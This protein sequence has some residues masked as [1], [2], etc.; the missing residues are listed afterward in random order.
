MH[1]QKHEKQTNNKP[2]V[3]NHIVFLGFVLIVLIG[4]YLHFHNT[5]SVMLGGIVL[6][7]A[8]VAVAAGIFYLARSYVMKL[9]L[10]FHEPP[11]ART[12]SHKNAKTFETE[13]L[14]ISW[15]FLY[16]L[17]VKG[18]LF[19]NERKLRES[20]VDLAR[21]Q[22]GEKVLDVGCG[23]GSLAIAAGV[24]AGPS[25]EIYGID[26]APE[27]IERARKKATKAGVDIDFQAGLVEAI[28]FPD[29]TFDIVLNSFMVHHL[30]GDLKSK[31][32]AEMYRVL[33]PGGRLLIV[34]FEPPKSRITK[35]ILTLFLTRYMMM[36]DNSKI[37]P[38]LGKVGFVSLKTG[39][40]G[41]SLA[42]FV[43]GMK[44]C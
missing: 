43:S 24:K 32:F 12:H 14:T 20:I 18:I 11:A 39:N 36:I 22:P 26:A 10:K 8:H 13:G 34:D 21:I 7:L 3:I 15:A 19:G 35:M 1:H 30:P 38:L 33:K 23:T 37:P 40:T 2:S 29:E 6:I 4:L 41:I 42:T 17:L 31:A 9:F 25:A 16:D 28:D 44:I 27:M 5:K